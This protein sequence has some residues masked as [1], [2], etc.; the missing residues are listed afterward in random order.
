M[1]GRS[2]SGVFL[3]IRERETAMVAHLSAISDEFYGRRIIAN[4]HVVDGVDAG[5]E[6]VESEEV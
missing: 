5:G 1:C 4:G 2:V 3:V 6:E